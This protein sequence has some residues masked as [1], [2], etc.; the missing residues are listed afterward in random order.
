MG[1]AR[2]WEDYILCGEGNVPV[3]LT[4]G[5]GGRDPLPGVPE[6]VTG[7]MEGD[8]HT[9]DVLTQLLGSLFINVQRSHL[10]VHFN[11][12]SAGQFNPYH[13]M[14]RG[15]RCYCDLNRPLEK[16]MDSPEAKPYYELYHSIFRPCL[17]IL[18]HSMP[19]TIL[20]YI[21]SAEAK[22]HTQHVLVIDIHGQSEKPEY[23]LR[24]TNN[25]ATVADLIESVGDHVHIGEESLF[26]MIE[27]KGYNVFPDPLHDGETQK[28]HP[29]V[30]TPSHHN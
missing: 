30:R 9:N 5:H 11:Q 22:F 23:V 12:Q 8:Q 18:A 16:A 20:S 15:H 28:E 24:G 1:D 27:S 3:I 2:K 10:I 29:K 26:G 25:G 14:A 17:I 6:R 4:A 7:Y 19:D 13:V 21:R